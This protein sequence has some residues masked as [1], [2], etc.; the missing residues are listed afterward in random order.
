MRLNWSESPDRTQTSH[1]K[2]TNSSGN[3][4]YMK[5]QQ[6]IYGYHD[7]RRSDQAGVF[8]Y[9][10]GNL[11]KLSFSRD[12]LNNQCYGTHWIK[13]VNLIGTNSI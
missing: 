1:I 6:D 5:S 8:D 2:K 4:T 3:G 12:S 9:N 11:R 13:A 10:L 7:N